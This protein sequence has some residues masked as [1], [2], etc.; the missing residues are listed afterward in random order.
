MQPILRW[1]DDTRLVR[2]PE[3]HGTRPRAPRRVRVGA[4]SGGRDRAPDASRSE[5]DRAGPDEA[6][7]LP[8]GGTRGFAAHSA[9]F[10]R[11]PR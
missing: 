6:E 4:R 10:L 9:S 11:R 1:R 8:A 3:G 5:A 2:P 7:K